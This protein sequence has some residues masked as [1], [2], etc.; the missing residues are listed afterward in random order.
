MT[1]TIVEYFSGL[2]SNW[3]TF[4]IGMLPVV[5]LR[6]AIPWAIWAA[7]L[8]WQEAVLWAVMGNTLPILPL[9]LLLEPVS[10]FLRRNK[11]MDRFFT[12]LFERTRRRGKKVME[13]YEALGLTLFVGIPLP[14]TGIWTGAI[15]AFVFGIRLKYALPAIFAGMLIA[16]AL[17]TL[18]S[19]G[20]L[21][22]LR[23]LL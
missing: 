6:G 5:E 16:G 19:L 9:L 3:V 15:A 7:K 4:V 11:L 21:G 14:G 2:P 8:P 12:W 23:F 1:E 10:D 20:I 18:A 17:I 22:F 13:K